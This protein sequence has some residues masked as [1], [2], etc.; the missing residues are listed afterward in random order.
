VDDSL[1]HLPMDLVT[2]KAGECLV[3]G[4]SRVPPKR[5]LYS[6]RLG[7]PAAVAAKETRLVNSALERGRKPPVARFWT[8]WVHLEMVC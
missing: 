5:R 7:S 1:D 4:Y 3:V 2:S 6:L 8:G